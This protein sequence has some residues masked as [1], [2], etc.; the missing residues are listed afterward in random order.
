VNLSEHHLILLMEEC[1]EVA[2]RASKQ[3]RFGAEEIQPGQP[4][5]N[6]FRLREELLDLLFCV[7]LLVDDGQLAPVNRYEVTQHGLKKREKVNK[8]IELSIKQGCLQANRGV[9]K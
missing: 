3:L 9:A 7:E 8:M 1:A 6:R 4:D 5:T 2:H